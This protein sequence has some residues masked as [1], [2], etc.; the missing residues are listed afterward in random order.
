MAVTLVATPGAADAN[1]YADLATATALL[2]GRTDADAWSKPNI[3]DDNRKR[4]LIQATTHIDTHPLRGV[5]DGANLGSLH[6]PTDTTV[7]SSDDLEIPAKVEEAAVE[8]ALAIIGLGA[9]APEYGQMQAAGVS[10]FSEGRL[11]V[12]FNTGQLSG[13]AKDVAN[14]AWIATPEVRKLLKKGTSQNQWE[15]WLGATAEKGQR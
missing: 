2:D 6:F 5:P 9:T 14:A 10:S 11:S 1:A 8:L 3:T 15:G 13:G 12:S 7:D 4:A